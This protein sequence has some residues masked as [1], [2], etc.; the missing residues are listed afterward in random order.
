M[1]PY[2]TIFSIYKRIGKITPFQVKRSHKGRGVTDIHYRYSQEGYTFMVEKVVLNGKESEA[3]G[4]CMVNGIRND[5]CVK[6]YYP[7]NNGEIPNARANSW[8]L[9]DVPGVDMSTIF[10][11]HTANEV[12]KSGKHKGKT[13]AEVNVIDPNY[14]D[15]LRNSNP[16]FKIDFSN[17]S[18]IHISN[19]NESHELLDLYEKSLPLVKVED[20]IP[21]GRYRGKTFRDVYSS[22]PQYIKWLFDNCN[23]INFDIVAFKEMMAIE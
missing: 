18:D 6:K 22:N 5:S 17:S 3:Y 16:Y 19:E 8:V 10:P 2:D 13:Y 15:W 4:Y 7:E 21:F 11:V 23:T 14:I 1:Y 20:K 12:I 9:I